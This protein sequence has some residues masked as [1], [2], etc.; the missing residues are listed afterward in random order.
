MRFRCFGEPERREPVILRSRKGD[1]MSKYTVS[2]IKLNETK[3][4]EEFVTAAGKCDFDI[5]IFY[6]RMIIDAKS[7]LG[8]LSLDHRNVVTVSYDG[9]DKQ[10]SDVVA[11]YAVN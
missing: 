1:I 8:I 2:K 11:K 9:N 3:E 10:F 7:I 6:N 5:D 4:V